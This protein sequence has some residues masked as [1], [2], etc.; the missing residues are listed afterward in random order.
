MRIVQTAERHATRLVAS[1]LAAGLAVCALTT[2]LATPDARGADEPDASGGAGQVGTQPEGAAPPL[3][4]LIR[5]L[6]QLEKR[7]EALEGEVKTL[8]QAD[9]EAWLS[10]QRAAEIRGLVQDVL[11]DA[12]SRASLQSG[13]MT[14]GWDDGFFLASPDG[15]F[16][17]EVG[18]LVQFR[19]VLSTVR[20]TPIASNI[21]AL[22]SDGM[23]QR[24][25]FDMANTQLWF[26]GHVFGPGLTYKLKGRFTSTNEVAFVSS[27]VRMTDEGSGNFQLQ[28]AW[29][30]FELDNNWYVRAGQ[31]RLPFSREELVDPDRQLAVDRS[32][33][34]YS[35]GLNYSQG[36]ELAYVSDYVRAAFAFS[37]GG[38][39]QVGGQMRLVG[40]NPAN[41]PWQYQP[42]DWSMTGR[43][44]WKPYGDWNEF[45][46]FTSPPGSDFGLLIGFGAHYQSTRPDFGRIVVG[47]FGNRGDNE[48]LMMTVDATANFGGASLF[49]AF[50]YSYIDTEAGWYAGSNAVLNGFSPNNV[51]DIGSSNKWAMILQGAMYVDPKWEFFAR[52]ELGQLT[53]GTPSNVGRL[54]VDSPPV[55]ETL[56]GRENHLHTFT[57]GANWYLDGHDVK[58]TGDFGYAVDS[59]G[60]SWFAPQTG[61]RVSQVR[62]E[63]VARLQLQ[64]AF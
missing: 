43:V 23:T 45:E 35:L 51:S 42:N 25:G 17:M 29:M 1:P 4:D 11:A 56:L 49:G 58:I 9:G 46:S 28:D 48:W 26:K 10:E 20:E 52:Y 60:A 14:A 21:P 31:F 6:D 38:D 18:G 3:A 47:P 64:L 8:R 57:V 44:E 13:G 63:W 33:A 24:G 30:R 19:Y 7:N 2:L 15:R 34:S 53:F 40:S 22:W 41:R 37:E 27:P 36:I 62:D 12:D 59:L 61:W 54:G 32:V 39:D 5:R 55:I 50:T 16:R